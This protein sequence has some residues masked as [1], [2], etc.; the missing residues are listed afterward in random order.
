MSKS[1]AVASPST[2][3]NKYHKVSPVYYWHVKCDGMDKCK[4]QDATR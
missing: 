3:G 4:R 2:C 1:R